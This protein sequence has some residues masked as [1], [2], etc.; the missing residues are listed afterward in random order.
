MLKLH[1]ALFSK[2]ETEPQRIKHKKEIS[3]HGK[4][5]ATSLTI[6]DFSAAH[7][8]GQNTKRQTNHQTSTFEQ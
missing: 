1:T 6:N 8:A 4:N 7:A 3:I 5:L 2:V